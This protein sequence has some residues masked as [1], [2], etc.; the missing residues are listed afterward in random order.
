MHM[1][2]K[3][4]DTIWFPRRTKSK[5]SIPKKFIQFLREVPLAGTPQLPQS[6]ARTFIA[7]G[8]SCITTKMVSLGHGKEF[9]NDRYFFWENLGCVRETLW[10]YGIP[11]FDIRPG[12]RIQ[13]IPKSPLLHFEAGRHNMLHRK[14]PS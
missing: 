8:S 4:L 14:M 10:D 12:A 5:F 13:R 2:S 11:S 6:G 3:H 9:Y 7:L 1:Q